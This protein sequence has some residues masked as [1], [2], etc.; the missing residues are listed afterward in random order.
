MLLRGNV[1][2]NANANAAEV[3]EGVTEG[4]ER[5]PSEIAPVGDAA[6]L[7]ALLARGDC[8]PTGT[9]DGADDEGCCDV[10]EG[11]GKF[12]LH[13]GACAPGLE[14]R[15]RTLVRA[16]EMEEIVR[17]EAALGLEPN[18]AELV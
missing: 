2:A 14:P 3:N 13:G 10:L 17:A 4:E 12:Y 11:C 5:A 7:A 1:D 8:A 15:V 6:F 18:Q 16:A 9:T